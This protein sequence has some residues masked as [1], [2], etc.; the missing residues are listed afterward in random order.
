MIG[1]SVKFKGT[2]TTESNP[3]NLLLYLIVCFSPFIAVFLLLRFGFAVFARGEGV[4]L[5]EHTVEIRIGGVAEAQGDF[6]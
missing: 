1:V 2:S 4:V 5:F 3:L 6:L